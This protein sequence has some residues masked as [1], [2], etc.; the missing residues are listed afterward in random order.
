MY[1]VKILCSILLFWGLSFSTFASNFLADTSQYIKINSDIESN[2]YMD[3][4]S[5]EVVRY[6]PPFYIIRGTVFRENYSNG[7]ISSLT[8][9]FFY[10]YDSQN[11]KY[12]YKK[13][14]KY[15]EG[16]ME[17]YS[18]EIQD[19]TPKNLPEYSTL[20][21]AANFFF[22]KNYNILFYKDSLE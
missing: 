8:C 15:S 17:T 18:K 14:A 22:F 2:T 6:E 4:S 19:S 16:G 20:G 12:T 11:V 7:D 9:T 5:T 10:N 3:I 1:I 21:M 13:V